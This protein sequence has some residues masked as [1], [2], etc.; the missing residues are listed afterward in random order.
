MTDLT[1]PFLETTDVNKRFGGIHAVQGLSMRLYPGRVTG[2]IGPN[3]AGKTTSF[4]LITGWLTPDSGRIVCKGQDITGWPPYKTAL[5]GIGRTWQDVRIF[6]GMTVMENVMLS[7]RNQAGERVER[8]LVAL[9]YVRA[10][11][12]A[13]RRHCLE[14]LELVGL[15]SKADSMALDLSY[16][17][18]K[19]LSIARA[20]AFDSEC[21]LLDEPMSGLDTETLAF[22]L[23]LIRRLAGEGRTVCLIEHNIDFIRDACDH[24]VFLDQGR[25][26]AEG[27]PAE[28]MGNRELADL[29]FGT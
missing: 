27:T 1:R 2:L 25:V 24:V 17:E 20:L 15:Q 22:T 8:A 16:A 13:N 23:Q 3:G 9:R 14:I 19:L 18:Q 26:L 6:Q 7:R 12:E 11:E 29:Y 10:Q 5:L 4:N 28:I 21:L